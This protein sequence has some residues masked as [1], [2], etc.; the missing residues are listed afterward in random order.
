M[1]IPYLSAV[2]VLSCPRGG[3]LGVCTP[4]QARGP[5]DGTLTLGDTAGAL[6]PPLRGA[7]QAARPLE[8]GVQTGDWALSP[9]LIPR[10]ALP[11]AKPLLRP[12]G[13][14]ATAARGGVAPL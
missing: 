5:P 11:F 3:C 7:V 12:P 4:A 10:C 9:P 1:N 8:A 6:L 2:L 13:G 14:A